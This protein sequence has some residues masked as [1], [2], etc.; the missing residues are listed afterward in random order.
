[1]TIVARPQVFR[2][3][4]TV[5]IT[6]AIFFAALIGVSLFK[7]ASGPSIWLAAACALAVLLVAIEWMIAKTQIVM[8]PMS[9]R[10]EGV[11][12]TDEVAWDRVAEYRYRIRGHSAG[13]GEVIPALVV[14]AVENHRGTPIAFELTLLGTDGQK[15]RITPSFQRAE[16]LRD[17]VLERMKPGMVAAGRSKF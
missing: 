3:T 1:M 9:I 16:Q 15:V 4:W 6:V 11:F 7:A 5:R 2:Q 17:L 8:T 10:R 12:G 13:T 14:A